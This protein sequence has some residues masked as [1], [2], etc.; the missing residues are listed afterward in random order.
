MR[1][2]RPYTGLWQPILVVVLFFGTIYYGIMAVNNRDLLWWWPWFDEMPSEIVMYRTGQKTVIT[3]DS[4]DYA[5]LVKAINESLSQRIGYLNLGVGEETLKEY[6]TE[7]AAVEVIYPSLVSM[8]SQYRLVP[9]D[10]LLMP[11]RGRHSESRVVFFGQE[12]RYLAGAI[13][14]ATTDPIKETL[15]DLGYW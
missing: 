5:P 11:L 13:Q 1:T 4:P 9:F 10:R 15:A 2:G 3:P 8:H 14:L 12:G 6:S 7:G